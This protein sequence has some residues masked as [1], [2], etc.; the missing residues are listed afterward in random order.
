MC[1]ATPM[2]PKLR[3]R[4]T[5]DMTSS[6][7]DVARYALEASSEAPACISALERIPQQALEAVF[8]AY[9][10]WT[11]TPAASTAQ[12]FNSLLQVAPQLEHEIYQHA[13]TQM[14]QCSAALGQDAWSQELCQ[15]ACDSTR[16][17]ML[18]AQFYQSFVSAASRKLAF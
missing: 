3:S 2:K 14:P 17:D 6:A 7:L 8:V 4:Y 12:A 16:L 1:P 10:A 18:A 13:A 11:C 9:C 5:S 15:L